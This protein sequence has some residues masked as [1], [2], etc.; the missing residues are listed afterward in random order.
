MPRNAI[1]EGPIR[2]APTAEQKASIDGADFVLRQS[3]RGT[4]AEARAAHNKAG[5]FL[6]VAEQVGDGVGKRMTGYQG[7]AKDAVGQIKQL[8]DNVQR[9]IPT[10]SGPVEAA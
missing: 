10:I 7:S 3:K 1:L 5:Q 8:R 9:G 6:D 2:V 4:L